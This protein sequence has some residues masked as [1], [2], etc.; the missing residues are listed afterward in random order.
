MSKDLLN[1]VKKV[2][3]LIKVTNE[4]RIY[5]YETIEGCEEYII[6]IDNNGTEQIDYYIE[7][8]H[9]DNRKNVIDDEINDIEPVFDDEI[10]DIEPVF[11]DEI[12]VS[13]NNC[14]YNNNDLV[15]CK[16]IICGQL[17]LCKVINNNYNHDSI[18]IECLS[19]FK[20]R[21]AIVN[22]KDCK[23]ATVKNVSDIVIKELKKDGITTIDIDCNILED[24]INNTNVINILK[25]FAS[26]IKIADNLTRLLNKENNNTMYNDSNDF[27]LSLLELYINYLY[28]DSIT[29]K[30]TF[31]HIKN[32]QIVE[33]KKALGIYKMF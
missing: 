8:L 13:N 32:F 21:K 7:G 26:S 22:I 6:Y 17:I 25:I 19:K 30:P 31:N 24:L 4:G 29:N 28:D 15:L 23:K 1:E 18:E 2:G 12:K 20:G 27:K 9:Y 16:N 11:D 3:N 10:N 14:K 5:E 33:L